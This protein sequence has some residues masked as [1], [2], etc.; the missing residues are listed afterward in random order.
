MCE[1]M[2]RKTKQFKI[3]EK[4]EENAKQN[5]KKST[6]KMQLVNL[7]YD[8]YQFSF[9]F[10]PVLHFV[11]ILFA[12]YSHFSAS[13]SRILILYLF[14]EAW[15]RRFVWLHLFFIL[16]VFLRILCAFLLAYVFMFFCI[17][18]A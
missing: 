4:L 11:C 16:F 15:P 5:A 1:A 13:F 14:S 3:L 9:L 6:R 8:N 7:D 12:S 2:P 17:S 18:G 10:A